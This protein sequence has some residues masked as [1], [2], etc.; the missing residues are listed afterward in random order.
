MFKKE[1]LNLSLI[2]TE[3]FISCEVWVSFFSGAS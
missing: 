1:V 3:V 2:Y